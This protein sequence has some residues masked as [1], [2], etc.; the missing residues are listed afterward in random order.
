MELH[1]EVTKLMGQKVDYCRAKPKE[2]G[3]TELFRGKGIVV[4]VI[5]GAARRIQI[6]VKDIDTDKNAAISL[7]TMCINPTKHEAKKYFDHHLKVKALVEQHNL[8]Q[9]KR[10]DDKIKEVDVINAKMFGPMLEV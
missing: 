4:G 6:M 5:I 3:T 8:A 7:D 9:K 2:D 10:E 1:K